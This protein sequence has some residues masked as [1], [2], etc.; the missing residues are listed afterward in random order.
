MGCCSY[1]ESKRKEKTWGHHKQNENPNEDINNK[2]NEYIMQKRAEFY[3]S[4]QFK[5]KTIFHND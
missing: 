2:D 3:Q 1:D 5:K 4:E